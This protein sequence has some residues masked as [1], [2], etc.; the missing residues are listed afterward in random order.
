MPVAGTSDEYGKSHGTLLQWTL[1]SGRVQR[2]PIPNRLLHESANSIA[3]TLAD[4]GLPCGPSPASHD[5]L[6]T[7]IFRIKPPKHIR[8]VARSGWHRIDDDDVYVLPSGEVFGKN[9]EIIVQTAGVKTGESTRASGTLAEWR[10]ISPASRSATAG[11]RSGYRRP[12][13]GRSGY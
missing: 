4:A 1:P 2:W 9:V 8:S 7:L 13:P 12:S 6:K 11:W 5:R 10:T 3:A